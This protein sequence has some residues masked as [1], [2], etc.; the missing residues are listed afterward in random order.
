M[1][2]CFREYIRECITINDEHK[3]QWPIEFLCRAQYH[4]AQILIKLGGHDREAEKLVEESCKVMWELIE[5]D[6]PDCLKT[7]DDMM[8][9]FDHLIPA[10]GGR[11]T[12]IKLLPLL[13]QL[14]QSQD[15]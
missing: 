8:V 4:L 15:E 5:I 11:F 3:C 10:Q 7:T 1:L 2:T 14:P 13:G 12:G 6:F 9:L